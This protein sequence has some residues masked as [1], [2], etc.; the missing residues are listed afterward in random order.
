MRY[1]H[2]AESDTVGVFDAQMLEEFE[3][4]F[5]VCAG[6]PIEEID[7][8]T[9]NRLAKLY[10]QDTRQ[11]H[12][13]F[14]DNLEFAQRGEELVADNLQAKFSD[15]KII[16]YNED[17]ECDILA[18]VGGKRVTIE[19]KEDVRTKD[20]GNIVIECESRGK[21]SGIKTTKA[22][23]WVFR[24]HQD[25]GILNILFK[26]KDL[27]QAIR[28]RRFHNKRQ[29][30]HTDSKNVLYFFRLDTLREYETIIF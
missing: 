27:K 20:T 26:T 9:Y 18:E 29:M 16:D 17:S 1:W 12:N 21:P 6:Q 28:D 15:F 23:F 22:D 5:G 13:D 8:E 25:D 3:G 4:N 24:V 7:E 30:P 2:H 19:V 11:D 10:D 14:L